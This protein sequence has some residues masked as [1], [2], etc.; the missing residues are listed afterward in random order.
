[1][2]RGR[3]AIQIEVTERQRMILEQI[4]RRDR[5]PQRDVR[6]ASIVLQS[7]EGAQNK[8]IAAS[9]K[10]HEQTVQCWR[11]RWSEAFGRLEQ[12]ETQIDDKELYA[13]IVDVL[14]DHPRSGCPATFTP[15]QVCRILAV[16]CESPEECGCPVSHWT[17]RELREEVIRRG[18]VEEISVRQMGRFL[19]SGGHKA[20]SDALLAQPRTRSRSRHV[21]SDRPQHL[22]GVSSGPKAV[23]TRYPRRQCG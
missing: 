18:I 10:T 17:P 23:S 9:L 14:S 5:S 13:L 19:K 12:V 22:H 16:A 15:E 2:P 1:M 7:A 21:R 6:R 8:E 4:V 3:Q 11:G 20:S